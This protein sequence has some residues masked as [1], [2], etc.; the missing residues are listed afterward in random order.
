MRPSAG[1]M[2]P[3]ERTTVRKHSIEWGSQLAYFFDLEN[4]TR[5]NFRGLDLEKTTVS[6]NNG[7][8]S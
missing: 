3:F 4:I 2:V 7:L 1:M 6:K 5:Y 8:Q